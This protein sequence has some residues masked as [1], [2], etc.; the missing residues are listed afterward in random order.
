MSE[1][2][3]PALTPEQWAAQLWESGSEDPIQSGPEGVFVGDCVSVGGVETPAAR[4]A[5]A[6][7]ALHGESFGFTWADVDLLRT[8]ADNHADRLEGYGVPHRDLADRIAALLPPREEGKEFSASSHFV[9]C[10][11][12]RD[13][14]AAVS[15]AEASWKCPACGRWVRG[16]NAMPA[17]EE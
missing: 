1:G 7:L 4:H 17:S 8:L 14:I 2:V 6:A 12:T 5:I 3:R 9:S 10:A 13:S 16:N 15:A 11:H